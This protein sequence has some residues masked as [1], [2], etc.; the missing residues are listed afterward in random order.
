MRNF[1]NVIAALTLALALLTPTLAGDGVMHT[2]VVAP[3][4]TPT[5][6]VEGINDGTADGK[7]I[8]HTGVAAPA[9]SPTD[10]M[11]AEVAAILAQSV[12]ALF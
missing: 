2:G 10:D 3:T 6:I 12:L 11:I 4:P 1:R 5:P 8:M 7:G 9:P